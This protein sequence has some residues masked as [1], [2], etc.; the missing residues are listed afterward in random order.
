MKTYTTVL[1]AGIVFGVL[2]YAADRL[3]ETG[4]NAVS[5]VTS[6]GGL[7]FRAIILTSLTTFAGLTPMLLGK[8]VQARFLIPMAV[9]L[10]FGVLFSTVITFVVIPCG[11]V[12]HRDILDALNGFRNRWFGIPTAEDTKPATPLGKLS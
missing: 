12:I 4:H 5:V 2:V 7:R 11:C 1:A 3:T 6:A 8:S 9:S 10:G